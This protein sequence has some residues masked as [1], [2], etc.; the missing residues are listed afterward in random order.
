MR[1]SE[2]FQMYFS[3]IL[4]VLRGFGAFQEC[5]KGSYDVTGDFSGSQGA[6]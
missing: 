1:I 5:L 4:E 6:L 2:A 3:I